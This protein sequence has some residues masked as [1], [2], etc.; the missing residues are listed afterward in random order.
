MITPFGTGD[1]VEVDTETV[2]TVARVRE[3]SGGGRLHIAFEMGQYMP[4]VDTDVQVRHFGN[5]ATRSCTA[6]II[7]AGAST[8]LLQLV[9]ISELPPDSQD[10]AR[11]PYDT[12]PSLD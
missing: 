7:H 6:K 1:L 4:W 8:A 5:D 2:R 3:S 11:G 10:P 9:G 12:I